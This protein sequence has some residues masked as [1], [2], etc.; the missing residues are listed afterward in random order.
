MIGVTWIDTPRGCVRTWPQQVGHRRPPREGAGHEADDRGGAEG[1]AGC[2]GVGEARA[3]DAVVVARGGDTAPPICEDRLAQF[4]GFGLLAFAQHDKCDT[5]TQAQ[6]GS[7]PEE[8][9]RPEGALGPTV[10]DGH[11]RACGKRRDRGG[12]GRCRPRLHAQGRAL[13]LFQDQIVT[14]IE[15]AWSR[16][17]DDVPAGIGR[18]V[19]AELRPCDHGV[20]EHDAHL[21]DRSG[22]KVDSQTREARQD[23][24]QIL[25][26]DRA[27]T[28]SLRH[29]PGELP[30]VQESRRYH[31]Q[32]LLADR[33]VEQLATARVKLMARLEKLQR[34]CVL[35]LLHGVAPL[36]EQGVGALLH[37]RRDRGRRSGDGKAQDDREEAGAESHGLLQVSP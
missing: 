1:V 13:S 27:A 12:Q 29:L 9:G 23:L 16:N 17:D 4:P 22:C 15:P 24:L 6:G 31:A 19:R 34:L 33:D 10:G 3:S 37:I 35:A 20:I 14:A 11:R 26:D 32:P 28:V 7:P 25:V 36:L 5:R 8:T 2:R 30:K 18:H 21:G